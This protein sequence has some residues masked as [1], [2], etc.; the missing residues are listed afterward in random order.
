M[1]VTSIYAASQSDS[2]ALPLYSLGVQAGFPSPAQDYTQ[3]S[4]DISA[5]MVK[6]KDAT[7]YLRVEGESLKEFRVDSGD[8]VVVDKSLQPLDNNLVI[9]ALDGELV[10]RRLR[11][12]GKRVFLSLGN[13]DEDAL[14]ITSSSSGETIEIWGTVTFVVHD[15]RSGG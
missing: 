8:I 4:L 1:R 15:L 7:F 5:Y 9:A 13:D 6:N 10:L 12:V 11:K 2:F 3:A 14:E